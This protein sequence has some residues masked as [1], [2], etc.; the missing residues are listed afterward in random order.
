MKY[1]EARKRLQGTIRF[2]RGMEGLEEVL[3]AAATAEADTAKWG[4]ETKRL[5][6]E[7]GEAADR[8]IDAKAKADGAENQAEIAIVR[9]NSRKD[10]A[11]LAA[12]NAEKRAGE[13]EETADTAE[14]NAKATHD[15]N[16]LALQEETWYWQNKLVD[17]KD[18]H[19]AF[20]RSLTGEQASETAS[21]PD[22]A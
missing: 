19:A 11:N 16:M 13:A 22:P 18:E 12:D 21:S 7:I 17:V 9:A 1:N 3:G 6:V 10:A 2:F 5:L 20:I 8:A 15:V 4:K 14:A